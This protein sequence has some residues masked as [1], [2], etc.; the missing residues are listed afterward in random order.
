MIE[1]FLTVTT[2]QLSRLQ[3]ALTAKD[4]ADIADTIRHYHPR[5]LDGAHERETGGGCMAY[6]V[7]LSASGR[8]FLVIWTTDDGADL[9]TDDDYMIGVYWEGE[10][11]GDALVL[12]EN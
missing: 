1:P 7:E 2:E 11:P 9:A 8:K 3:E 10:W 4:H 12:I 6:I 5:T